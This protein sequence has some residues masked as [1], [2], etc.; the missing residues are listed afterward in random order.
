[1]QAADLRALN[2]KIREV[3]SNTTLVVPCRKTVYPNDHVN[4]TIMRDSKGT[5]HYV[6]RAQFAA[7]VEPA[8]WQSPPNGSRVPYAPAALSTFEDVCRN[9]VTA[10]DGAGTELDTYNQFRNR[11]SSGLSWATAKHPEGRTTHNI[12]N[13]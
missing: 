5:D 4:K 2:W 8:I 13:S 6:D 12:G 1:M 11:L 3:V 10:N 9:L 7:F